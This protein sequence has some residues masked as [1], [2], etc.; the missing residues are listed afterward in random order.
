MTLTKRVAR[1]AGRFV[2]RRPWIAFGV[3]AG[4]TITT[5]YGVVSALVQILG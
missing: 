2:D 3:V 4:T 5:G 1:G